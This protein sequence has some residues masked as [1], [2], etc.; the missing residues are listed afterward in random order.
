MEPRLVRLYQDELTHLRE[1]GSE[2]ATEFPKIDTGLMDG[3]LTFRQ[4][5]GGHTDGPNWPVFL[6]FADR[7]FKSMK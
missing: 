5:S 3:T 1:V 6:D 2:F 4:H 7:E